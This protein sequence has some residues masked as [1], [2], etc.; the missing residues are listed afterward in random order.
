MKTNTRNQGFVLTAVLMLLIIV[1]LAGGAFL[2]SARNSF[3]TVDRW[4]ERDECLLSVQA[5]LEQ[6]KYAVDSHFRAVCAADK[7]WACMNDLAN[8]IGSGNYVWTNTRCSQPYVIT[9]AVTVASSGV[10]RNTNGYTAEVVL[11]NIATATYGRVTRRVR[12]VVR[13]FYASSVF[14]GGSVFDNVYYLDH[15]ASFNGVNGDFNGDVK[16][17]GNL[18]FQNCSSLKFNGDVSAGGRVLN[19]S[20][21]NYDWYDSEYLSNPRARPLLY[22]DRNT[23][24]SN[25]Y[26]PQ[27]YS[28]T[29]NRYDGVPPPEMPYIGPLS[30]YEAYAVATT[31]RLTQGGS[32]VNAVWGDDSGETSGLGITNGSDRGCLVITNGAVLNGVVVARGDVYIK[33]KISGQGT[34]Y[35]GRN[36]YVIGD[37][38]YSNAP[39]WPKPDSNP[40]NTASINRTKDFVGLCAKGNL[41]LGNDFKSFLQTLAKAPITH[42]HAADASDTALGYVS[43][44]SNGIS[45]FNGDYTAV[46]GQNHDSVRSD[47][48]PRQFYEPI[49]SDAKFNSLGVAASISKIDGVIYANHMIAGTLGSATI[50]GGV[51]CRD[52]VLKRTGNLYLNWDIR[53]G[54][55]S[56]ERLGGGAGLP[57]MLPRQP[58]IYYTVR[59]EELAP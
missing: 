48:S 29:V 45:M 36:I 33:G 35:A 42:T 6:A 11:T 50:N 25:T 23:S 15:S 44:T 49:L 37:L 3:A 4:R 30:E 31:G 38:S 53:L 40:S 21:G 27:G 14:S 1:T 2:F 17:A 19:Y 59:W 22:T 34:I 10:L 51:I 52:E 20:S 57:D 46:D 54:S 13:Y 55:R 9:V 7:S 26:W 56:Y 5:G 43:Y 28:G 16:V 18:D 41:I 58:T 12:E 8:P 47:G 32:T 24:N 39:A